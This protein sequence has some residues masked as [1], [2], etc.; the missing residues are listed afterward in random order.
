VARGFLGVGIQDLTPELAQA[1]KVPDQSGA[2][3][4]DVEP[5]S[6]GDKA[7]LQRGD[8]IRSVNGDQVEDARQLRLRIGSTKP[9]ETVQLTVLRDGQ[10][11][12]L[13]AKLAE[14]SPPES[15]T[16]SRSGGESSPLDGVQVDELTPAIARQLDLRPDTQG[17][18]VTAVGASSGAY[19]AGLRRGDV[20]QEVDRKPVETVSDFRTAL[21]N[22]E[23]PSVVLLVNTRGTIRFLAINP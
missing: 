17:V 20:I 16:I 23:G 12:T 7:G 19:A 22:A 10:S 21:R 9:G 3:V 4:R 15:E 8:V 13:T 11:R 2:L 6:A 5:G 18:V 14:M 1:M